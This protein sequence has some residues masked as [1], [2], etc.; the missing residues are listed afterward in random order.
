MAE[1]QE[2]HWWFA[3]R[4]RII[5]SVIRGEAL[6]PKAKILEIGC[7]TGGNLATLAS[8]GQLQ[9]MESNEIAR[10]IAAKLGV[11]T[12][13]YGELPEP[14]PFDNCSFD[15]VCLLDV[16]EH[17]EEDEMA[18]SRAG[19]LLKPSGRLL[20]TVPAYSWLWSA[21]DN[22]HH[23]YRRYTANMLRQRAESAGL[24][25]SRLGYFSTLLFP[26]IA[27][28]RILRHLNRDKKKSS[29]AALPS[30]LYNVMLTKIFGAER[31]F[32]KFRLFPFGTS[33]MAILTPQPC[34]H[35]RP[36]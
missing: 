17:I 5:A 34:I 9:A 2:M 25:V 15:L 3:A 10:S 16:L 31:H 6:P 27:S 35:P 32:V 19:H 18:L 20:V 28:I 24:V 11:C 21:H 7:G 12:I 1:V 23:H 30:P 8:F 36:R 22:V 29:D 33:L 26:I 14:I 4:R 13:A